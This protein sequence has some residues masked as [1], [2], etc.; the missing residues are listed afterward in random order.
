M[1]TPSEIAAAKIKGL[2]PKI[3]G[4]D[5]DER[6]HS[7]RLITRYMENLTDDLGYDKKKSLQTQLAVNKTVMDALGTLADFRQQPREETR[8][9]DAERLLIDIADC[10]STME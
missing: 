9:Y 1:H 4:K 5:M 6:E 2:I 10:I 8:R 3:L 7:R